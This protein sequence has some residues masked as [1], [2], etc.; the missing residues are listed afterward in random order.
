MQMNDNKFM[1]QTHSKHRVQH[2]LLLLTC[3]FPDDSEQ[4]QEQKSNKTWNAQM[5]ENE[6]HNKRNKVRKTHQHTR[7]HTHMQMAI[8]KE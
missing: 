1:T 4:S 7:V 2:E 3:R 8:V 6:T 5:I